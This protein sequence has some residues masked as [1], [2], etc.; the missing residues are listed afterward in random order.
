MPLGK[1]SERGHL[2]VADGEQPDAPVLKLVGD[3]LQLDQLR[4][5][6]GSPARAAIEE[7]GRTATTAGGV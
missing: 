6:V 2:V 4:L 5:A 3:A 1:V 7:D